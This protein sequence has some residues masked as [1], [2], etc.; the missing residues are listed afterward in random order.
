MFKAINWISPRMWQLIFSNYVR[1]NGPF[2]SPRVPLGSRPPCL[3]CAH[4]LCS[5]VAS[6][7]PGPAS[8][9]SIKGW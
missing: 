2:R 9:L 7:V 3:T 4:R 6:N 1:K 5:F 8:Q